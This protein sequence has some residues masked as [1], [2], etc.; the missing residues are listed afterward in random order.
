MK[1]E[2]QMNRI[3]TLMLLAFGLLLIAGTAG[4]TIIGAIENRHA[5]A[6]EG[7]TDPAALHAE[8]EDGRQ[9]A[10]ILGVTGMD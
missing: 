7:A 10:Y 3:K 8:E 4:C 2:N 5:G 9:I 1:L 6:G